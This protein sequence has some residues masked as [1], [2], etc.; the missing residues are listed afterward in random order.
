MNTPGSI[1]DGKYVVVDILSSEGGMGEILRVHAQVDP[2]QT[3]ALKYCLATDA[4]PLDRFRREVRLMSEF[5]G[6]SK[7]VQ[8]LDHRHPIAPEK[9]G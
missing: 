8:I 9:G 4:E 6:N 3:F 2:T 1:I 5:V 7:V